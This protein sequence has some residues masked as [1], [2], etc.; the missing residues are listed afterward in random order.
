MTAFVVAIPARYGST[1]L[2]GKPLRTIAGQPMI[3]HVYRRALVGGA[4]SVVIA[5]DDARIAEVAAGFGADVC[6]TAPTH[7]SGTD[8]LAEV[9]RVRGWSDDTIV[10]NL[11]GDEPLMPPALLRQVA[12]GLERHPPAGIATLCTRIGDVHEVF[13]PHSVKVVR[14]AEG[15]ALYFSRAA[16]PYH[17][18]AFARDSGRPEGLPGGSDYFRHLGLYAYRAGTLHRFA[19]RPPCPLEQTESLEQ[20]RAL[21]NGIRIYVAEAVVLPPAGVDTEADLVRVEAWLAERKGSL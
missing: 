20:L 4:A 13:D 21:W 17:R 11:Q 10:V 16:I 3:E 14:D 2:P 7:A 19:G 1:R 18:E 15:Y 5:T 9:A 12:E 8:R 6:M